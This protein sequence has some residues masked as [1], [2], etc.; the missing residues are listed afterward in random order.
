V[1]WIVPLFLL[2]TRLGLTD[3]LVVLG[4]VYGAL[5]APFG[6]YLMHTHYKDGIPFEVREAAAVDGASTW[7][8]LLHILLPLS[9][10]ALA[11][12]GALSFVWSW[13]DLLLAVVMLQDSSRWTLTVAASTLVSRFDAAIQQQA[14][15][16]LVSIAPLLIVFLGAQRAIA[17]G[18]TAG[19]GK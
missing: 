8:Q 6:L 5:I 1:I 16:A 19:I 15:A 2:M 14:A 3:N 18:L 17:R 13:G 4:V 7:Q 10:P 9:K 12:L 11:A